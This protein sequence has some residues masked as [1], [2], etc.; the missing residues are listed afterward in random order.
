M[1]RYS[2][3]IILGAFILIIIITTI[4]SDSWV[5]NMGKALYWLI[6]ATAVFSLGVWCWRKHLE[7]K[8]QGAPSEGH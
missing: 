3:G 4:S 2:T 5:L 1:L 8:M 7:K 6:V